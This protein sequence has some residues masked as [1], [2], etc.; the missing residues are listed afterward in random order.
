VSEA[1]L[2]TGGAGFIGSHLVERLAGD[3]HE[4]AVYDSF[5]DYYP[6]EVKWR[7]LRSLVSAGRIDLEVGDVRDP[8]ALG[9]A[10][11]SRPIATVIHLAA[12][13]GV[14]PSLAEPALYADVNVT[15]TLRVLEAARAA[16]VGH[17]V[18][19]SSSS[20][21]G[22]VDRLPLAEDRSEGTPA[23]PYG[24]SKRAMEVVA[25]TFAAAFSLPV[26]ALR[27]F[28]AY[29]PRQRPDMAIHKFARAILDGTPIALYGE[30]SSRRDYTFVGDVVDGIV[31]AMAR[32]G[33]P[34]YR[35]Y[36]LGRE[37]PVTLDALVDALEAALGRR[38]E[39]RHEAARPGDVRAT[40][41]DGTRARRELGFE[42]RVTLADGLGEF[43][44]WLEAE[45]S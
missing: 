33:G 18:V 5:D 37:E 1:V 25:A 4:V 19:A 26:T 40:A 10:F 35:V 43:A 2:V 11:A 9:R 3:G 21:Y 30:G 36:N 45:G 12:R 34:A 17:V 15:G 38:A 29:G 8:V 20:V 7:N 44:R 28:T 42:P 16:G 22:D 6:P 32:R 31:R 14:Q 39:R 24:A 13:A 23:S 27:F 41:A